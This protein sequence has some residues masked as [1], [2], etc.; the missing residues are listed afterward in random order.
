L[1]PRA[2]TGLKTEIRIVVRINVSTI[3][4]KIKIERDVGTRAI[5]G[6]KIRKDNIKVTIKV[7]VRAI[8][9][10]DYIA[11]VG[12]TKGSRDAK[13]GIKFK[14]RIRIIKIKVSTKARTRIRIIK[15]YTRSIMFRF[16]RIASY[17][18]IVSGVRKESRLEVC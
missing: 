13:S 10:T 12:R 7:S 17:R 16:V 4:A 3:K 15:V 8:F 14:V 2:K 5:R 1:K 6:V 11:E 18:A 9:S